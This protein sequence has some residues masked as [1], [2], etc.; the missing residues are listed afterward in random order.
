MAVVAGAAVA[1]SS[2]GG[3]SEY[4]PPGPFEGRAFF[5]VAPLG[6]KERPLRVMTAPASPNRWSRG[7]VT[8]GGTRPAEA[9]PPHLRVCAVNATGVAADRTER[10]AGTS[11]LPG[12][13]QA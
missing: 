13:R 11:V 2:A 7:R 4:R 10:G 1:R 3:Y 5:V 12:G 8:T 9:R 6:P